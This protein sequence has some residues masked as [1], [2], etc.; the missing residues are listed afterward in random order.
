VGTLCIIFAEV[1]SLSQFADSSALYSPANPQSLLLYIIGAILTG[2]GSGLLMLGYG[3]LYRSVEPL[4]AGIE[5]AFAFIIAA[6]FLPV[7]SYLPAPIASLLCAL[8]PLVSG[9]LLSK[10]FNVEMARSPRPI[11]HEIRLSRFSWRI[12]LCACLIGLADG[13]VRAVFMNSGTTTIGDFY[14]FPLAWASLITFVIITTG[15]LF[16]GERGLRPIYRMVMLI[17]ALFF[18]LL[19]V[20]AGYSAV[21]NTLALTGYGTF[22]LL[23]WILL[24]EM[25]YLYRLSSIMVFGI[26]WGMVSFGVFLGSNSGWLV[27]SLAPFSPQVISLIALI[28]TLT[29]LVS[30]MFVFKEKDL[31]RLIV[32][33]EDNESEPHQRRFQERC[34]VISQEYHLSPKE[35]EIMVLFAKGRSS[36]RI[37]QD[38]YISRGTCTT[39]LRHIYQKLNVH[40]K[41]EFLDLIENYRPEL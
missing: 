8:L 15:M 35:S 22:N 11:T 7:F 29:I 36:A 30:Y 31:E 18:M 23:I 13:V 37:Q 32:P 14:R 6:L 21:E 4:K 26:G 25:V 12:G 3:E 40:D 34:K 24:A 41:Q 10:M 16:V 20:F 2:F 28:A 19:P 38:L 1:F 5:T 39:H 17:M 9:F 33:V 27:S